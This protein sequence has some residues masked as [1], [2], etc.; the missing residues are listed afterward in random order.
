[1]M[2]FL[3][4]KLRKSPRSNKSFDEETNTYLTNKLMEIIINQI[5]DYHIKKFDPFIWEKRETID[6]NPYG[7]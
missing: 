3:R 1:M 7:N 2:N 5:R 6:F 4:K